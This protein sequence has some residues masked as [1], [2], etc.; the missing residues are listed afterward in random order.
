[1]QIN[2]RPVRAV[3]AWPIRGLQIGSVS[4]PT[5]HALL[6]TKAES[7]PPPLPLPLPPALFSSSLC[8]PC[9]PLLLSLSGIQ[10]SFTRGGRGG[11]TISVPSTMPQWPLPF[12]PYPPSK[13]GYWSP[14]TSTLNWCEEV[15]KAFCLPSL[16]PLRGLTFGML[17]CDRIT[18]RPSTLPRS[19]IL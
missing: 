15:N 2:D 7:Q 4:L 19:S 12:V 3:P 16:M 13:D 18:M 5:S 8:C 17:Q 14:V 11:H 9:I 1:M 6:S 10:L